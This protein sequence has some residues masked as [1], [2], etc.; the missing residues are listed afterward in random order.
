MVVAII[1]RVV[2]A[3][4]AL[5]IRLTTIS[6]DLPSARSGSG[7]L[8]SRRRSWSGIGDNWLHT[9]L[10]RDPLGVVGDTRPHAWISRVGTAISPRCR[11]LHEPE[12]ATLAHQGAAAVT[13]AS[14]CC[15]SVVVAIGAKHVI[16]D[17]STIVAVA[18]LIRLDVHCCL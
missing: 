9:A 10:L 7:W 8:G 3:L 18:L 11:T 12:A 13:L 6:N 16:G 2:Q 15:A 5:A 1:Q 14:I 17:G 4:D